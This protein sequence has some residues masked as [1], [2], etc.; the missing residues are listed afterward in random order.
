MLLLPP[1]YLQKSSISFFFRDFYK[2]CKE[3]WSI[4]PDVITGKPIYRHAQ[5]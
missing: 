4:D 5:A 3:N 2:K 1:Q